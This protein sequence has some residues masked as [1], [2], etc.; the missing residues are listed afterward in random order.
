MHQSTNKKQIKTNANQKL[1]I[2][3]RAYKN[4]I[5]K[6]IHIVVDVINQTEEATITEERKLIWYVFCEE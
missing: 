4:R 5:E 2:Q 1:G 3:V 6:H